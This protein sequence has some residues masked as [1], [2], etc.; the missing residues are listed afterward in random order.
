MANNAEQKEG[1]PHMKSLTSHMQRAPTSS[2]CRVQMLWGM[3]CAR[4]QELW[5]SCGVVVSLK[6][7]APWQVQLSLQFV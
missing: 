3:I 5:H 4:G 6:M 1:R 7:P 2:P